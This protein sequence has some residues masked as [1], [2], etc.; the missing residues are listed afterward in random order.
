VEISDNV[1]SCMAPRQ[2]GVAAPHRQRTIGAILLA[3]LGMSMSLTLRREGRA[4][5]GE[6]LGH[7]LPATT[8]KKHALHWSKPR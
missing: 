6:N 3:M 8:Q 4:A 1:A 2:H 5:P 7:V